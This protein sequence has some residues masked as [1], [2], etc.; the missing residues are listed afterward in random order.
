[1]IDAFNIVQRRQ[2]WWIVLLEGIAAFLLGLYLII[3]PFKA[4]IL[5][6]TAIGYYLLVMGILALVDA[7]SHEG[8]SRGWKAVSGIAGIIGGILVIIK[9]LLGATLIPSI[10]ILY[11]AILC[12]LHGVTQVISGARGGGP[13]AVG[14]GIL[15]IVLSV[16]L[17][18]VFPLLLAALPFLLGICGIIG[19]ILLTAMAFRIRPQQLQTQQQYRTP[20]TR[21]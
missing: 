21:T 12:L 16:I 18:I 15:S 13:E 6:A 20:Q 2:A 4:I 10:L 5:V 19:G 1:M 9:P 3:S 8:P 7:F 17:F 11:L 14:V